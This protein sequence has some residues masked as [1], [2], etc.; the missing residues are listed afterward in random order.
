MK[1][2]LLLI[3]A[4]AI[5]SFSR[6]TSNENAIESKTNAIEEKE[7]KNQYQQFLKSKQ[8]KS[9]KA[10][11]IPYKFGE[12]STDSILI[13]ETHYTKNGY[14]EDSIIYKENKV[15]ATESFT[16]N[17]QDKLIK[18]ELL[19][20]NN[21][22]ISVLERV[23]NENG[24]EKSFKAY[25]LDTLRYSQQKAYDDANNL[26]KITDYYNDGSVRSISA[27]D[28]NSKGDIVNRKEMDNFGRVVAKQTIGYDSEGRKIKEA[29]YDSTGN[30]ISKTLI[31]NYNK[32]NKIQLIEKYNSSDSMVAR[33]EFEYNEDGNETK[34][35]IYNGINQILRQSLTTYDEKG[36]RISFK[37]YEGSV[38]LLGSDE[39]KYNDQG[40]EIE[41]KVLNGE[42]TLD[43]RKVKE[44]NQKQLLVKEINY[45][46]LNEPEFEFRY[47][48]SY[49]SKK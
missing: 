7:E 38:G 10:V 14:L 15:L 3:I 31:K 20:E 22:L 24:D 8:V 19:N 47:E 33:Y 11:A 2:N 1:F 27:F 18:R 36:N 13:Y 37:I 44:Y 39:T 45:N 41:T 42:N 4:L 32:N 30:I 48:Y 16:Y 6:C 17:E 5:V 46:K 29:E 26:T 43:N 28:Y 49:F 25:K 12:P 23:F 35:T 40:L 21:E 9:K 34:N